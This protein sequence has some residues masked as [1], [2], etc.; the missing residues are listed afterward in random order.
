MTCHVYRTRLIEVAHGG[1]HLGAESAHLEPRLAV[2]LDACPA[3]ADFLAAQ[4][5][6][7]AATRAVTRRHN[8]TAL[9]R[10]LES[11]LLAEFEAVR[12]VAPK[13]RYWWLTA[14]AFAAAAILMAIT[15]QLRKPEP[16]FVAI[17]PAPAPVVAPEQ[18]A[19][20][21]LRPVTVP[22]RPLRPASV[23]APKPK[24]QP[25][26]EAF[27]SIPYTM[28]LTPGERADVV[29]MDVPV[30]ALIAAGLPMRVRDMSASA[31]ADFIVGEDGRAR[32]V[33]LVSVSDPTYRSY[34]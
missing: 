11:E 24:P 1:S 8:T 12:V 2:H 29:R 18:P 13:P 6:L 19:P 22:P 4:R 34:K 31:S 14:T 16:K 15:L 23:R 21:G 30:A 26:E 10:G 32:A 9:P 3:C 20:T 27:V 7:S 28:P 25:E 17:A 33:R 5:R